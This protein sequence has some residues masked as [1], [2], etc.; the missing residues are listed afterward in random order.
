MRLFYFL[1][2]NQLIL[3][4]NAKAFFNFQKT[5]TLL[6]VVVIKIQKTEQNLTKIL[7]MGIEIKPVYEKRTKKY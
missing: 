2:K 6:R 3:M 7:I 4:K 1:K 5:N